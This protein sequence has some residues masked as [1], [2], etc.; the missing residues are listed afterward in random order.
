MIDRLADTLAEVQD[1][2][3]HFDT[4]EQILDEDIAAATKGCFTDMVVKTLAVSPSLTAIEFG[5]MGNADNGA[6]IL[7][8]LL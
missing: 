4:N 2:R 1:F 3:V 8:T 6:R 7:D 5:N